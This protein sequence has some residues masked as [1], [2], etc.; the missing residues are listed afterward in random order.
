[1]PSSVGLIGV[2]SSSGGGSGFQN[3]ASATLSMGAQNVTFTG[4]NSIWTVLPSAGGSGIDTAAG[5]AAAAGGGIVQLFE[6]TYSVTSE[7]SVL[8]NYENVTIQGVGPGTVLEADATTPFDN[9]AVF[10]FDA[11][12]GQLNVNNYSAGASSITF[13]TAS[14]AG[15]VAAGDLLNVHGTDANSELDT[16]V[17]EALENGNPGTGVVNLKRV[18][19]KTLT[20]VVVEVL[21][22]ARNCVIKD[23]KIKL[24][25]G[26]AVTYAI[27]FSHS[28]YCRFENLI[29]ED[30]ANTGSIA[31]HVQGSVSPTVEN[32][33]I[34]NTALYC[35][36]FNYCT[37]A[38][39][40]RNYMNKVA[41]DATAGSGGIFLNQQATDCDLLYNEVYNSLDNGIHLASSSNVNCRRINIIG[42]KISRVAAIGLEMVRGIDCKIMYNDFDRCLGTYCVSEHTA[43]RR[44]IFKGN[45][46]QNSA[47]CT[48]HNGSLNPVVVGNTG[49]TMSANGINFQGSATD[50]VCVGN[51]LRSCG[52]RSIYLSAIVRGVCSSNYVQDSA[53]TAIKCEDASTGLVISSNSTNGSSTAG[54]S[55]SDDTTS[56]LVIGN[57]CPDGLTTGTGITNDFVGN[58]T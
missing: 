7:I 30:F 47:R 43:P 6:G 11:F 42:N 55:V 22:N 37:G 56:T 35:I 51:N 32:C 12:G 38:R 19:R 8:T 45:S 58:K 18:T 39:A 33:Q 10:F 41:Q 16:E 24:V 40:I 17:L 31:I 27:D 5:L 29:I 54:L 2:S 53:G 4:G 36:N 15:N 28:A 3:P 20:S 1:M 49:R 13:T 21:N 52:D 48:N 26:S 14:Q 50:I 57:Y 34:T 9:D 46:F 25:G 23:L 44:N